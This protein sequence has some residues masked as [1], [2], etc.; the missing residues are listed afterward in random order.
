MAK[1]HGIAFDEDGFSEKK[2]KIYRILVGCI[3]LL[4]I[5]VGFFFGQDFNEMKR[6][7]DAWEEDLSAIEGETVSTEKY[8]TDFTT[9]VIV[10]TKYNLSRV[11]EALALYALTHANQLP[12]TLQTLVDEALIT[13]EEVCD[14]WGQPFVYQP[15]PSSPNGYILR[16]VGKDGRPSHDDIAVTPIR[17]R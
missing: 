10:R 7:G 15:D 3:I 6:A 14:V 16:S 17:Q 13:Q 12:E 9:P 11:Q 2:T 4:G 1:E 5:G 8:D